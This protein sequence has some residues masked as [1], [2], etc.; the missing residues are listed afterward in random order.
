MTK[1][2][3]K[4]KKGKSSHRSE[5]SLMSR[6]HWDEVDNTELE[7]DPI[8]PTSKQRKK[9]SRRKK[10][11]EPV[12]DVL[13]E[14]GV[15]EFY[16]D[17][18]DDL[19]LPS[20]G[21]TKLT[22]D[23][24]LFFESLTHKS[25]KQTSDNS[26]QEKKRDKSKTKK[27]RSRT[28]DKK[29]PAERSVKNVSSDSVSQDSSDW[30]KKTECV[31]HL[32]SRKVEPLSGTSPEEPLSDSRLKW[33]KKK[34]LACLRS[35]NPEQAGELTRFLSTT[36]HVSSVEILSRLLE[37][38]LKAFQ[39][40]AQS[41]KKDVH[42]HS[43]STGG[44]LAAPPE[45]TAAP[46]EEKIPFY[47]YLD[48]MDDSED[49]E[50]AISSEVRQ[51]EKPVGKTSSKHG[52]KT[53]KKAAVSTLTD[54]PSSPVEAPSEAAST[55][56]R[57]GPT[58]SSCQEPSQPEPES[59]RKK[60]T[61]KSKQKSTQT[62]NKFGDLEVSP[63]MLKM[64]REANYE[65]P[66]PVQAGTIPRVMAGKDLMGQAKTGTGKT[67]A[68]LI[69]IIEQVEDCE[70]GNDPVALIIVP[71]RELAVQVRDEAIKLSENR[72]IITVACYGGK[73]IVDQVK[74][75]RG[76]VDI[77]VGTPG[78][79]I[80]LL[81][82][83]A[84]SLKSLRWVVLDEADRM[85]DIGFR[86]DI[87]R[88]LKQTPSDRQTLLF[89]ATLAPPVVRL[90]QKYMKNPEQYDFSQEDISSETIEQFYI[91]VDKERKFGALVKLLE[92]EAP[93]QAIVFC[94]TKRT[95]DKVGQRLRERF[96]NI[97]SIHGDMIQSHRDRVMSEFR[98]GKSTILVATDVVGRGIDISGISHI[99]N[100]DIPQ[101][102]DDYV[103]RVGRTGRMGHEGVAFTLVT[104][105]E[106][107]E[108]TRIEKRINRLLNRAELTGFEAYTKPMRSNEEEIK[109]V[110]KPVFGQPT[111]RIRRAL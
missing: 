28:D 30:Q 7:E 47:E 53:K 35:T 59:Q 6:F 51:P 52:K 90:A 86:P 79:I 91:T 8:V 62:L 97:A 66:T 4:T 83:D 2:Y 38:L 56:G 78:R 60:A 95:V 41:A 46:P 92:Q 55:A 108:L 26:N 107:A 11:L 88:I 87:E 84:L 5:K 25:Q 82:R 65:T 89:S 17:D 24:D 99:I 68:F 39:S 111:R 9:H 80:D 48:S 100:Y 18:D 104:S 69:P 16:N 31:D 102:C 58:G 85:L 103:H 70:P 72:D 20:Y 33:F 101:F 36:Q 98:K 42:S 106:G 37:S 1:Q 74:K 19:S 3:Q 27:S 109:V 105:Q 44:R 81:K 71:T 77:I 96:S 23:D 57:K 93:R 40:L 76:G 94:R 14:Q 29:T 67:A 61:L 73:P 21:R 54:V 34:T 49:D 13:E 50:M 10:N 45:T 15:P 64:L 22:A 32:K 63:K 43:E 12:R 110:K 75:L